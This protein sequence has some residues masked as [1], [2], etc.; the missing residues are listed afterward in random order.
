MAVPQAVSGGVSAWWGLGLLVFP[1]LS[2]GCFLH[3]IRWMGGHYFCD[4]KTF[5]FYIFTYD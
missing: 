3:A 5:F 2:V 4:T 1:S